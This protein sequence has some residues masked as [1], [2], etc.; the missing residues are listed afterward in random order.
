MK[1][2]EEFGKLKY[3]IPS[4]ITSGFS[5][6]TQEGFMLRTKILNLL[7]MFLE[8]NGEIKLSYPQLCEK[9]DIYQDLYNMKFSDYNNIPTFMNQEEEWVFITDMLPYNLQ[10]LQN[11]NEDIMLLNYPVI[12]LIKCKHVQLY[13]E[14]YI[15]IMQINTKCKKAVIEEFS[16]KLFQSLNN[17]FKAINMNSR[18]VEYTPIDNYSK[19]LGFFCSVNGVDNIEAL[20]QCSLIDKTLLDNFRVNNNYEYFDIGGSQRLYS[21]WYDNNS[22]EQ[23]IYWPK[24][25]RDIDFY[26]VFNNEFAD[27]NLLN[28]LKNNFERIQF[29]NNLGKCKL[30]NI[31]RKAIDEG[32]AVFL[33][34]IVDNGKEMIRFYTR[35]KRQGILQDVHE[36]EQLKTMIDTVEEYF[37]LG[38]EKVF[39]QKKE[40]EGLRV[41]EKHSSGIIRQNGFFDLY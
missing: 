12:R 27:Y 41:R 35:D 31:K 14:C 1:K 24:A 18:F 3:V 2:V 23:G 4:G 26:C 15:S 10:K 20:L 37:Y 16:Y 36:L 34:H 17:F 32:A 38:K 39:E 19:K 9:K 25:M 29:D 28:Q 13:T 30:K 8:E 7:T 22:D 6:W 33:I 5:L 21:V 40:K 11:L